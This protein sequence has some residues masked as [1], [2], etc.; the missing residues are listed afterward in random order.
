VVGG[1]IEVIQLS[2]SCIDKIIRLGFCSELPLSRDQTVT[3]TY[4][5]DAGRATRQKHATILGS[6]NKRILSTDLQFHRFSINSNPPVHF[7]TD[8]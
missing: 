2:V 6:N 7:I 1:S 8:Q 4:L 5:F 3:F